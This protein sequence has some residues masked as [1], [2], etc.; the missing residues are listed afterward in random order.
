M[1]EPVHNPSPPKEE[2]PDY[3][4]D[5]DFYFQEVAIKVEQSIFRVPQIF[6]EDGLEFFDKE[7]LIT[8]P[9]PEIIVLGV[10]AQEFHALLSVLY[11]RATLGARTDPTLCSAEW[12]AVNRLSKRWSFKQIEKI[13]RDAL[14][15]STD[16]PIQRMEI[17]MRNALELEM[18][19]SAVI[20]F[21]IKGST[22][23]EMV[24]NKIGLGMA[25]RIEKLR[26]YLLGCD[27]SGFNYS[28]PAK[29]EGEGREVVMEWYGSKSVSV[30]KVKNLKH[31]WFA[32][33][34]VT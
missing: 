9:V 7:T 34:A 5:E 23:D 19:P 30:P 16:P 20:A 24:V 14:I 8:T 33:K 13:S 11:T 29:R 25:L 10:T 18:M 3:E 31:P 32:R 28:F 1:E 15:A 22:I 26:G 12:E 4:R 2:T 27:G 17:A 6:L 21:L